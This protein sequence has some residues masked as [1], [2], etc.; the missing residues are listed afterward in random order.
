[1]DVIPEKIA[2]GLRKIPDCKEPG[3]GKGPSD[4]NCR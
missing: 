1:M 2:D 3:N 4:D